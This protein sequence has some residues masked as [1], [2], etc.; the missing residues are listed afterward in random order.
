MVS[1]GG[2]V[3]FIPFLFVVRIG[4]LGGGRHAYK[5]LFVWFAW[6]LVRKRDTIGDYQP[7]EISEMISQFS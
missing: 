5:G 2:V 3:R 1:G 7:I 4:G 6:G